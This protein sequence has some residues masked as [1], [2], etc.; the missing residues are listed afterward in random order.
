[1][2]FDQS[3]L[4]VLQEPNWQ[5]SGYDTDLFAKTVDAAMNLISGGSRA[6]HVYVQHDAGA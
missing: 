4:M 2:V 5:M 6:T 3:E 1:M